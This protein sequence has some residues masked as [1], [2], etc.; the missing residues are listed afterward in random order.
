MPIDHDYSE[1]LKSFGS[2]KFPELWPNQRY[3]LTEY[4]R[5]YTASSDVAV[6]LPTGAGKTL[7]ALLIAEAWRREKKK[8]AILSANKTLARQMGRE[9]A[10]L[11]I[12]AVLMEGRGIDIPA[13]DK[14]SF[15]R[16]QRVAIM[17][18]WVYFNQKPVI[19]PGDLIIMD[20]AHLAEHCLHSLYSVE[21]DRHRHQ[22]LFK[23]LVS[24]IYARF[25][26]YS[27]LA[28][29]LDDNLSSSSPPELLSFIDQCEISDR[30]R[31]IV[32]LS[33]ELR[34]DADIRFRWERVRNSLKEAN[35]YLGLHSIWIRPYIYPLLSNPHYEQAQQRIYMSATIGDP[36]DLAR[37]LGVREIIKIPVPAEF[38]EKT[39][40]RRLI[41]MNRIEEEDIP[42]RLQAVILGAL[43]ILPKSVWLCSSDAGAAKFQRAVSAWLDGNGFPGHPTW[44]L[45]S[46]GDE[47]DQ[48]KQSQSGHLFVA[49]RFDGMDFNA[50]ECR[51]VVITTI[52]R[53]INTQ[54]EFISAYLRDSGFMRNRLNQ[55]IIQALGRCNRSDDDYGLYVLADRRF[56]THFGRESNRSGLPRNIVAEIDMA[57]DHA[58]ISVGDLVTKVE[59]FLHAHFDEYDKDLS[60]YLADVP[61]QPPAQNDVH[62]APEEILGWTALFNNH[63]YQVAADRFEACW[64]AARSANLL[65]IGALHGWNWAKS[66][67]LQGLLGEPAARDRALE[68]LEQSIDRGGRS[69][70]FNRM[71]ASLNR[72]RAIDPFPPALFQEEY[73]AVLLRTFDD[74]LEQL[75]VAG[76]K[77][78]RFC[79]LIDS[80]L[81]STRH[82]EFREGLGKLGSLLG[83]S[84]SRPRHGA[85]TDCRWRG[86]FGN[87]REVLTLEAKI[88]HSAAGRIVPSDVGQAH[89]QY[90]RAVAEYSAQGFVVRGVIV[91]H[92]DEIAPEA[93]SAAGPIKIVS[94]EAA[95]ALWRRLRE[96]LSLYRDSWSLDDLHAR[97]NS[98]QRVRPSIPPTGWL[99]RA[100]DSQDRHVSEQGLLAE[101]R[102]E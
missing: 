100:L 35:I 51:L 52:P 83:Y 101:W 34:S 54:E 40:G 20:D 60:A 55:R 26:Q 6:E 95:I 9:A 47:I 66:Q 62:T 21:I 18:Y 16:S 36:E 30:L 29:A 19:D 63:N 79:N 85:A 12:P 78:Q 76:D 56:A 46:N 33:P 87:N 41:V 48:F 43:K 53:A 58:E 4:S 89:N 102:T 98:A 37:R 90:N 44:I 67:Y 38:A 65:E 10:A 31:E 3:V 68:T 73:A 24:E 82:D 92:L 99:G 5:S 7:I 8:V 97:L 94:K 71:R 22:N 39:S 59:Q 57:Q 64:T 72:A 80:R 81:A 70:W 91:T 13:S 84:A 88:E 2:A 49:G 27:V 96:L 61:D 75:G 42:R 32:D 28:D 15:Q 86:V 14:R 25:S 69:S 93:E 45:T 17:N 23:T 11:G 74:Q 50:D 1:F 77:F